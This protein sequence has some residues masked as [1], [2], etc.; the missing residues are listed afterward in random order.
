MV[1]A[2]SKWVLVRVVGTCLDT[3]AGPV[4]VLGVTV[5]KAEVVVVVERTQRAAT[6]ARMEATKRAMLFFSCLLIGI[7]DQCPGHPSRL[8][9]SAGID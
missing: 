6:S 4:R 7:A 1:G 8:G 9:H 5:T 2:V 3:N